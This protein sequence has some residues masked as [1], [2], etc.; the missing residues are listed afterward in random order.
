MKTHNMPQQV[1]V[2]SA[3]PDLSLPSVHHGKKTPSESAFPAGADQGWL[4]STFNRLMS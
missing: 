2:S 3:I 4:L 1:S